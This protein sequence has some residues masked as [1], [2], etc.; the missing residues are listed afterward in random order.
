MTEAKPTFELKSGQLILNGKYRVEEFLGQGAFA[1]VYRAH[2]LE[3]KVDRALKVVS[4]DTPGVGSTV[5]DDFRARFR[6]EAQL[7]ARLDHPHVIRIHDFEETEGQLYLVM[8]YAAGGS[9]A[10]LL[11]ERGPLPVTEAVRLTLEAASG[12]EA[13]HGLGAVHRDVKP[14]NLLLDA[15][16]HTKLA[17]LGLAQLPGGLSKRSLAGSLAPGHPGTPEYMSPEQ[18]TTS[19]FLTASS[20]IYSLGCVLFEA[21]TGRLW[22]HAMAEM[23]DVRELR[24]EVPAGVAAALSRMLRDQPGR[25]RADSEDP[26]KRYVTMGAVHQA[27]QEAQRAEEQQARWQ[28]LYR[29]AR[30]ALARHD[31]TAGIAALESLLAQVPDYADAAALLAEARAAQQRRQ[32]IEQ[33]TGQARQQQE[34]GDWVG[35][36]ETARRLK[37][38]S[39]EAARPFLE[40]LT[41]EQKAWAARQAQ[42]YEQGKWALE[43]H[44]YSAAIASLQ[45][46]HT[47]AP[48]YYADAATLLA[49]A[50]A[51]Q[52]RQQ[53]IER[54][55]GQ[56]RRQQQA[57]DWASLKETARQIQALSEPAA[58]PFLDALAAEEQRQKAEAARRDRERQATEA[59]RRRRARRAAEPARGA[60]E[61][62]LPPLRFP[63]FEPVQEPAPL[64]ARRRSGCG[65]LWVVG[66]LAAGVLA[67]WLVKPQSMQ[68]LVESIW[69]ALHSPSATQ[70]GAVLISK[71]T[72]CHDLTRVRNAKLDAAGWKA[73]IDRMRNTNGAQVTPREED[74][75]VRYLSL[76]SDLSSTA[77]PPSSAHLEALVDQRCTD[78]HDLT[79]VRNAK[80]DTAGWKAT[81]DRMRT[82][83]GAQVSQD[84]ENQLI[85]YLA[86]LY[87]P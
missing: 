70:A 43:R 32:A 5:L 8:E 39:E 34:A 40:A 19:A 86:S 46:L 18:E 60:T 31:P 21:L 74:V 64:P 71:C 37:P 58:R 41:A 49:D 76:V 63:P 66:V 36:K 15:G 4:Q 28:Q 38:V 69:A 23:E 72:R 26:T 10:R 17:D 9:L 20:D 30:D 42:R 25:K 85:P 65:W 68:P 24:P 3:L 2:H 56:A 61:S 67:V 51:Q 45:D 13:F 7:G 59:T 55:T 6:Q 54:L 11:K 16:G 27:L 78:C 79:R 44:D 57:G 62:E 33:L 52:Q 75:V 80:H 83:N 81:V 35:L 47:E 53:S 14:S 84:E 29:Q 22:K 48:G 12:L 82:T 73:T 50:R 1:Q 87:H 77:S